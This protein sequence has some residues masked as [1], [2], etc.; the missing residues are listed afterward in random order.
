MKKINILLVVLFFTPFCHAQSAWDGTT[1][2][3]PV[4]NGMKYTITKPEHLA[5]VADACAT[6]EAAREFEGKEVI[7]D[8]DLDLGNKE[9]TPIGTPEHPFRG[10]VIG[11]NHT[12]K[13]LKISNAS[14][15]YVGLFGYVKGQD[16]SR[17]K[18]DSIYL[19]NS[20]ITGGNN[21]GTLCGSASNAEFIHIGVKTAA[22]N[23][24]TRVGGMVGT[25]KNSAISISYAK[26]ITMT[27]TEEW[28]GLMVGYN[29]TIIRSTLK[30]NNCYAKGQ[31]TCANHGGGFVGYNGFK[32][33]IEHCY[34]IIRF[35]GKVADCKNLGLFCSVNE[36][37]A[38]LNNCVYNNSVNGNMTSSPVY[39]NNN[40]MEDQVDVWDQSVESMKGLTFFTNF[41]ADQGAKGKWMQDFSLPAGTGYAINEGTPILTWE[42]MANVSVK[43]ADEVQVAIYPNPVQNMLSVKTNANI[44]KLELMDLLGKTLM[45]QE[46]AESV[47]MGQFRAG[48]YLIRITTDQGTVTQKVI[49]K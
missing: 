14:L 37:N 8:A 22:L 48:I 16:A 13:N 33:N 7:I 30:I 11:K 47:N 46:E 35:A 9:W 49:K 24:K 36:H 1:K 42:Y 32:G 29:D 41:T 44:Q 10:H 5:W 6:D 15:D 20:T 23:G 26:G 34:C 12:I 17:A 28:G 18:I 3:K 19:T 2:T 21:V 25:L 43:E 38:K 27:V 4:V 40:E 39:T 45:V 31:I